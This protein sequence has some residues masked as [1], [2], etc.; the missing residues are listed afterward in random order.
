M[1]CPVPESALGC[2]GADSVLPADV[3]GRAVVAR[4]DPDLHRNLRKRR[5]LI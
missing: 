3:V 2:L 1:Q 5:A 4:L